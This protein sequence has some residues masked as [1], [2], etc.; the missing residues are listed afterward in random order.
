M[1]MALP[2]ISSFHPLA[3]QKCLTSLKFSNILLTQ[4]SAAYSTP[5]QAGKGRALQNQ[6]MAV[7]NLMTVKMSLTNLNKQSLLLGQIMGS[8]FLLHIFQRVPMSQPPI[9]VFVQTTEPELQ[10]KRQGQY[11]GPK[12]CMFCC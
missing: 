9:I 2:T 5:S 3:H 6:P 10:D 11:V 4:S 12:V 7:N 8:V 1:F